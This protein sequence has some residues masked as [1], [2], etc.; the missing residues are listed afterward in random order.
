[1][2]VL[3][4]SERRAAEGADV[5]R[6]LDLATLEVLPGS[7]VDEELRH[8][9]ADLLYAT[10]TADGREALVYVLFEHQSSFDAQHRRCPPPSTSASGRRRHDRRAGGALHE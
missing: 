5:R 1:V 10:R 6:Q 9:H 3:R 7:F 2:R 8:A 4:G